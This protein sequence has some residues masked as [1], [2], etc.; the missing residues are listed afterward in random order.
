MSHHPSRHGIG[1][2]ERV[3]YK[4]K[5]IALYR[6]AGRRPWHW[7]VW[8]EDLH[9]DGVVRDRYLQGSSRQPFGTRTRALRSAMEDVQR[10]VK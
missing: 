4:G 1:R 7:A 3:T 6:T 5:V 2:A 9:D 10:I 8:H